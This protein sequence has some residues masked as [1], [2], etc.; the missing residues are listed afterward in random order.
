MLQVVWFK[1]DLRIYDNEALSRALPPRFC[2]FTYLNRSTGR[3]KIPVIASGC[4]S[5]KLLT[6]FLR[7]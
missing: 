1:R 6:T 4:S 2:A 7:S 3:W 5:G